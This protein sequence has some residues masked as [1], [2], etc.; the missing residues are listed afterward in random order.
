MALQRKYFLPVDTCVSIY[1]MASCDFILVFFSSE[2]LKIVK[3]RYVFGV[4]GITGIAVLYALRV[5]LSVAIVT[6]VNHTALPEPLLDNESLA[7]TCPGKLEN[8]DTPLGLV[9][10]AFFWGYAAGQL[11][12]GLLAERYGGKLVFGL[13][14]F[15]TALLTLVSPFLLWW[16][17][18]FRFFKDTSIT[19]D[20]KLNK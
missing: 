17:D 4:M 16:H 12:G 20:T 13:G 10:A 6:M 18:K 8:A 1:L 9:L 2:N 19:T 5:N 7:D 15:L 11:P 3:A 14:V